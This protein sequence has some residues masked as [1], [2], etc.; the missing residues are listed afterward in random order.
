MVRY[1]FLLLGLLA[2]A[3]NGHAEAPVPKGAGENPPC[4]VYLLRHAEK[5]KSAGRNPALSAEGKVRAAALANLLRDIKV[6]HI[7]STDFLRTRETVA[8][9]VANSGLSVTLYDPQD[10]PG[11]AKKLCVKPEISVVVGHSNT[12]PQMVAL[13]G[14]EPGPAIDEASEFDRLYLLVMQSGQVVTQLYRYGN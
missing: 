2:V 9:L 12:T 14:G 5:L 4:I 8:P 6:G 3:G 11:T 10:L 1:L 13:L 7:Y